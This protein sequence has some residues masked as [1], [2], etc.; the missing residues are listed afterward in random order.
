MTVR[1]SSTSCCQTALYPVRLVAVTDKADALGIAHLARTGWFRQACNQIGELLPDAVSA[2]APAQ[3]EGQVPR[4]GERIRHSLKSFGI[5]LSKV[6]CAAFERAVRC[7]GDRHQLRFIVAP[8]DAAEMEDLR[9]LHARP[10]AADGNRWLTDC[11]QSGLERS[12]R[13]SYRA[14][15]DLHIIPYIG[16]LL[17][18][19]VNIPTIRN[20]QKRLHDEGRSADLIS[21]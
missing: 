17:L 4:P 5:R 14:H 15:L 19:K 10:H 8:E 6:G 13:D 9:S 3:S 11:E 1:L 7:R 16:E 2:D 21:R 20:W 18:T 12:T